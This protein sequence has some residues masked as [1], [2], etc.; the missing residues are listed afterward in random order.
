MAQRLHGTR[1]T[2]MESRSGFLPAVGVIAKGQATP[3]VGYGRW[4]RVVPTGDRV[5]RAVRQVSILLDTEP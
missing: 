5:G 1:R 3:G 4:P 2:S